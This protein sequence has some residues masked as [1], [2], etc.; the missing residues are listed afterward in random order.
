MNFANLEMLYAADIINS[1]AS[2]LIF[3]CSMKNDTKIKILKTIILQ[4]TS[5]HACPLKCF[6]PSE[7]HFIFKPFPT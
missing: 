7:R 1:V 2:I 4:T 5:I 3:V 6:M